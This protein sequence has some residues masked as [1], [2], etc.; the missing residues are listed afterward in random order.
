M[1]YPSDRCV[2]ILQQMMSISMYLDHV[3][4]EGLLCGTELLERPMQLH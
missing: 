4:N 1:S 2:S 3:C